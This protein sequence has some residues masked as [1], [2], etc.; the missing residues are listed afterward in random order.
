MKNYFCADCKVLEIFT[1]SAEKVIE[2]SKSVSY[3][4]CYLQCKQ[5]LV[6]QKI[7]KTPRFLLESTLFVKKHLKKLEMVLLICNKLV[8]FQYL[9]NLAY[10]ISMFNDLIFFILQEFTTLLCFVLFSFC[11][12]FLLS[13]FK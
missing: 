6:S 7:N 11:C 5:N 2:I 13:K 10:K 1:R 3:I 8:L 12:C 4:I 9:I